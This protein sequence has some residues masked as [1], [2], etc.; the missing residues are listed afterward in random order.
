MDVKEEKRRLEILCSE[1]EKVSKKRSKSTVV[2]DDKEDEVEQFLALLDRIQATKKMFNQKCSYTKEICRKEHCYKNMSPWKPSF[3]WE[4]FHKGGKSNG[5]PEEKD[6]VSHTTYNR[7]RSVENQREGI[8]S[9]NHV[10]VWSSG[11]YAVI[12]LN[13]EATP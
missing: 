9:G 1:Q 5:C 4:D 8:G 11:E 2:S 7:D 6:L 13:V 3:Q 12:D 10:R